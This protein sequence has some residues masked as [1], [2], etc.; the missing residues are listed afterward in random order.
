MRLLGI[1]VWFLFFISCNNSVEKP[2][3][4]NECSN[5]VFPKDTFHFQSNSKDWS[6]ILYSFTQPVELSIEPERKGF[7]VIVDRN[8][9]IVEGPAH[10]CLTSGKTNFFFTVNLLNTGDSL[11]QMV[12]YRSPKTVNPDSNI[13]HQSIIHKVDRFQNLETVIDANFFFEREYILSPV[14]KTY[15]AIEDKPLTAYYMQAGSC[16]KIP[17]SS[18]FDADKGRFNISAGILKDKYGNNIADGSLI[19]FIY[20]NGK[21]IYRQESLVKNGFAYAQIPSKNQEIYKLYAET[22]NVKSG[23]I[24]LKYS[25]KETVKIKNII[26]VKEERK[27]PEKPLIKTELPKTTSTPAKVLSKTMEIDE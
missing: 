1:L 11:S 5:F 18:S 12:D 22:N 9:G 13:Q 8:S 4:V 2:I 7:R 24:E 10:L 25:T 16:A 6:A 19:R 15:R 26:E 27:K 21:N 3:W 23:V 20:A 17:I 14:V